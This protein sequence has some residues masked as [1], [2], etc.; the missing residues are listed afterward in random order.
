MPST[1][2]DLLRPSCPSLY[3]L[4]LSSPAILLCQ[5]STCGTSLFLSPLLAAHAPAL[6][7][8][9][10]ITSGLLRSPDGA[11]AAHYAARA[12]GDAYG[13]AWTAAVAARLGVSVRKVSHRGLRAGAVPAGVV[14]AGGG[15]DEPVCVAVG[16]LVGVVAR[17]LESDFEE[18]L[19]REVGYL[20]GVGWRKG[21]AQVRTAEL[22]SQLWRQTDFRSERESPVVKRRVARGRAW[23]AVDRGREL[24]QGDVCGWLF[25]EI[26]IRF[27]VV[28]K[29]GAYASRVIARALVDCLAVEM[30]G[31][32]IMGFVRAV[33]VQGEDAEFGDALE[34]M[35][36]MV[37]GLRK[38]GREQTNGEREVGFAQMG[39]E[40]L[41]GFSKR[42]RLLIALVKVATPSDSTKVDFHKHALPPG[43]VNELGDT[44]ST[45]EIVDFVFWMG[46]LEMLRRLDAY[47]LPSSGRSDDERRHV[48]FMGDMAARARAALQDEGFDVGVTTAALA[49]DDVLTSSVVHERKEVFPLVPRYPSHRIGVR[50]LSVLG[51]SSSRGASSIVSREPSFV[52]Q[53]ADAPHPDTLA[54]MLYNF[55]IPF[56][57]LKVRHYGMMKLQKLMLGN[58]TNMDSYLAIYPPGLRSY[59]LMIPN[60][61]NVPNLLLGTGT[62]T[63]VIAV[64]LH[65]SS[66]AAK[67]RYCSLH[68]CCM[69]FF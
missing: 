37:G 7:S 34:R 29:A 1:L 63:S 35:G 4:S 38:F 65:Y 48:P 54:A 55:R 46:L 22:G 62:P 25:D 43:L 20:E 60:M 19:V 2:A 5:R 59:M 27:Q 10:H 33:V 32:L 58:A 30:R 3:T 61:L 17:L 57:R 51:F 42:E 23:K 6:V 44:F 45:P 67:S 47:Y 26:G 36:V 18:A 41:A 39:G 66:R 64:A 53:P 8:F 11:V 13:A 68:T 56:A 21:V 69:F 16:G 15:A 9:T 50:A 31:K 52:G 12:S 24:G 40:A 28:G 49:H 14:D